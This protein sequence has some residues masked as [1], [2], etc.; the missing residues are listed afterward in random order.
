M[1]D[2]RDDA[3]RD[4]SL[5][6]AARV[7][8]PRNPAHPTYSPKMTPGTPGPAHPK[9]V[10]GMTIHTA[11]RQRKAAQAAAS[12]PS[13]LSAAPQRAEAGRY[14]SSTRCFPAGSCT[15]WKTVSASRTGMLRPFTRACQPGKPGL[16]GDHRGGAGQ[17]GV[18]RHPPGAA[19]A[20]LTRLA[21]SQFDCVQTHGPGS[22]LFVDIHSAGAL[23]HQFLPLV[24]GLV[25]YGVADG[26]ALPVRAGLPWARRCCRSA[27]RDSPRSGR[28]RTSRRSCKGSPAG[29]C[30]P[31][32]RPAD[33]AKSR[34]YPG[35]CASYAGK[36]RDDCAAASRRSHC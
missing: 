19:P 4:T 30:P 35:L 33:H 27:R 16:G 2:G 5:R 24:P 34:Q 7:C 15:D 1:R 18:D 29:L 17:L 12:T 20:S 25:A 22:G 28:S 26:E 32:R 36:H 31:G 9:P 21:A 23:E 8:E 6:R 10:C 13:R 11:R 14:H 3:P